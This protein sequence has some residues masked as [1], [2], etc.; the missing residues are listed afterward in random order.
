MSL[1]K[2]W[3]NEVHEGCYSYSLHLR[4]YQMYFVRN[5]IDVLHE[6][7]KKNLEPVHMVPICLCFLLFIN[8]LLTSILVSLCLIIIIFNT[9]EPKVVHVEKASRPN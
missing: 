1:W 7:I 9:S 4:F 8:F 3:T 5:R 6:L 2:I